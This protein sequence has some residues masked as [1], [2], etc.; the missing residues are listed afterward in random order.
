MHGYR[1]FLSGINAPLPRPTMRAR[2]SV[3]RRGAAD[4]SNGRLRAD[5]ISHACAAV[6]REFFHG[7][8]QYTLAARATIPTASTGS[9]PTIRPDGEWARGRLRSAARSMPGTFKLGDLMRIGVAV[10]L[11]SGKPYSMWRS[12]SIQQR[13]RQ[14][15]P[16]ACRQQPRFPATRMSICAGRA[17]L[18]VRKGRADEARAH[19]GLDAFNVLN[20]SALR[21]HRHDG[22]PLF[23]RAI[24]AQRLPPPAL[25][26]A[27]F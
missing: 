7:Q 5:S 24:A 12:G 6:W 17:I 11:Y 21:V 4:R 13:P 22:S 25:A 15:R 9:P 8:L 3:T 26:S 23:G 10:S 14:R 18:L 27:K 19:T 16:P 2:E 1:L 20:R